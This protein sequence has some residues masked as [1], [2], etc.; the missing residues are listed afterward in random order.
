MFTVNS[1]WWGG[2]MAL[3]LFSTIPHLRAFCY[4]TLCIFFSK[5]SRSTNHLVHM[6][7]FTTTFC[8]NFAEIYMISHF[9][10]NRYRFGD[11]P[12]NY[13]A[14]SQAFHICFCQH[15]S[16]KAKT[17][18]LF[19]FFPTAFQK[20]FRKNF[21]GICSCF[22]I[23][24]LVQLLPWT[25][26]RVL[27]YWLFPWTLFCPRLDDVLKC[28]ARFLCGEKWL[29]IKICIFSNVVISI[30]NFIS[31]FFPF[32]VSFLRLNCLRD[33]TCDNIFQAS[34]LRN[35]QCYFCQ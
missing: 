33:R 31:F 25:S 32:A 7:L 18:T 13:N 26:I 22:K 34:A 12:R 4:S 30:C 28:V 16:T 1:S 3:T 29:S 15:K 5:L 11:C 21:T 2:N 17:L 35:C 9:C 24:F 14:F 10:I 8:F 23:L 19:V 20:S 6:H 27:V